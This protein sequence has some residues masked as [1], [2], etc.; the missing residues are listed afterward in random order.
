MSVFSCAAGGAVECGRCGVC[1]WNWSCSSRPPSPV[2]A[3]PRTDRF[4]PRR[5]GRSQLP[6]SLTALSAIHPHHRP[7]RC[8]AATSPQRTPTRAST[9][10]SRCAVHGRPQVN[11]LQPQIRAASRLSPSANPPPVAVAPR[12]GQFDDLTPFAAASC[13]LSRLR[14]V[15]RAPRGLLPP[16]NSTAPPSRL[17]VARAL[18]VTP[19]R[20]PPNPSP[21]SLR[22]PCHDFSLPPLPLRLVPKPAR[23]FSCPTAPLH[24]EGRRISPWSPV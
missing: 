14:F 15:A 18:R 20:R 12:P 22:R 2:S 7:S 11:A 4:R 19:T 8:R 24:L 1:G 5:P 10:V 3:G 17:P 21:D 16:D 6:S 9:T 23:P 13:L